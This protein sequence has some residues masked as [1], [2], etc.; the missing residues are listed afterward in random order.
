MYMSTYLFNHRKNKSYS[1]KFNEQTLFDGLTALEDVEEYEDD[2]ITNDIKTEIM[3]NPDTEELVLERQNI[4][5][6]YICLC[7]LIGNDFLPHLNG[8][9]ILTNSINDLLN[10]YI[11]IIVIR[12]K[13]LVIDGNINFIFIRQI[14]TY[15]FSNEKSYLP[16]LR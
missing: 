7:F 5:N 13:H 12:H 6:D 15:L 16:K 8:I 11:S 10:I 3:S 9:D 1:L 4:I 2:D 14:L